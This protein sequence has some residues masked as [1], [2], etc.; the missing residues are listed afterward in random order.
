MM[1]KI[2]LVFVLITCVA[3]SL[4]MAETIDIKYLSKGVKNEKAF[5]KSSGKFLWQSAAKAERFTDKGKPMLYITE[6]GSG[7][8]GKDKRY[9]TWSSEAYYNF[10][11]LVAVPYQTKLVYKDKSGS[12]LQTIEKIY[13]VEGKRAVCRI[14]GKDQGFTMNDDLIDK[15]VLGTAL[16]NYPFSEK[17][18]LVFHLLTNEPKI[19]PMTIK[20]IGQEDLKLGDK[21]VACYK[22][23]MIPDLGALNIFGAFVP[24][25]YFWYTVDEPH[26]F[27]RYEGLESGMGTPYIVI[28]EQL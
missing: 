20:Y 27:M 9:K 22:I 19:Y 18:D 13:D 5:E 6:N 21:T 26:D 3:L 4:C 17:R 7:I 25:T 10:R 23:Q 28:E 14:D 24:K 16:A 15:E 12:V 8:Y 2:F 11:G 1:K